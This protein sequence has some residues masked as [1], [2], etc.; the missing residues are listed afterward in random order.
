[1]Y[2]LTHASFL[3]DLFSDMFGFKKMKGRER[4]RGGEDTEKK[5]SMLNQ[6][7]HLGYVWYTGLNW[8]NY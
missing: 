2:S 5:K 7:I 6:K 8:T 4:K 3:V 1:M